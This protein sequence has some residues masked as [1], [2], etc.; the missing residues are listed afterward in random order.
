MAAGTAVPHARRG[1]GA[2]RIDVS[3]RERVSL[4]ERPGEVQGRRLQHSLFNVLQG[5][6]RDLRQ[7][8]CR[9][10]AGRVAHQGGV[11]LE[12]AL[13]LYEGAAHGGTE[14]VQ[15]RQFLGA[16]ILGVDGCHDSRWRAQAS[17]SVSGLIQDR[18]Q[19]VSKGANHLQSFPALGGRLPGRPVR[20]A[21]AT[22]A[23]GPNRG[24][25]GGAKARHR[26]R[27]LPQARRDGALP[28]RLP[29]GPVGER[30]VRQAPRHAP[31]RLR[32]HRGGELRL[33]V[34]HAG[35]PWGLPQRPR[36]RAWRAFARS[37]VPGGASAAAGLPLLQ[38]PSGAGARRL[39]RGGP[40][41][42]WAALA[43]STSALLLGLHAGRRKTPGLGGVDVLGQ[44]PEPQDRRGL[45]PTSEC[46]EG[47]EI[48]PVTASVEESRDAH[49]S[50]PCAA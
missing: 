50:A 6:L 44:P 19:H 45:N 7:T 43:A 41:R 38:P 8:R 14:L 12:L 30:S 10:P 23:R 2:V 31:A 34:G 15:P 35:G 26:R 13:D 39:H 49:A 1:S 4:E 11:L 17:P 47:A 42:R 36:R 40:H 16:G 33:D 46:H 37:V 24:S 27:S 29:Y 25:G 3:V 21:S 9:G 22:L 28:R 18:A 20:V 32:H 48:A 5:R